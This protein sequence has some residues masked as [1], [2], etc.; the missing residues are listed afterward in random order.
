MSRGRVGKGR[1]LGEVGRKAR[2]V[3]RSSQGCL[4]DAGEQG[5]WRGREKT[6]ESEEGWATEVPFYLTWVH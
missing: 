2:T 1:G 6:L 4:G 3:G 5:V